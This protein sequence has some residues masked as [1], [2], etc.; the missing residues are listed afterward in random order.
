MPEYHPKGGEVIIWD[1]DADSSYWV[2]M[3]N[4]DTAARL[5]EGLGAWD[6]AR[7]AAQKLAGPKG[8]IWKRDKN[9]HFE[10]LTK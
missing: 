1:T 8:P 2:G 10:K 6:R 4:R 7:K 5:F 3:H 9:G